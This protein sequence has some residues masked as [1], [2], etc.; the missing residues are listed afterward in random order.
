[1]ASR[2]RDAFFFSVQTFST[3][4]YGGLSPGN[5]AANILV[6]V[7]AMA[8]VIT[9]ALATG[10][11]FARFARPRAK[12]TFSRQAV[13]APFRGGRALMVRVA[14]NSRSMLTQVDGSDP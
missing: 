2:L 7:E 11:V 14:N 8:G 12:I 1:M 4:G 5:L 13:I 10:S 6:T 3:I 9:T